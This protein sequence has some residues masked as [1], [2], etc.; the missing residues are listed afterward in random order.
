MICQLSARSSNSVTDLR[1]LE[2]ATLMTVAEEILEREERESWTNLHEA[3]AKLYDL[4]GAMRVEALALGGVKRWNLPEPAR[5]PRPY[6]RAEPQ[7]V[8]PAEAF[9]LM[10]AS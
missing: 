9:G 6:D 8:S 3:V 7:V 1:A 5:M 4:L 10:R 2:P